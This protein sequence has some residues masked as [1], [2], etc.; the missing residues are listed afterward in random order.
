MIPDAFCFYVGIRVI[1][2][3]SVFIS[4]D[5][6]AKDKS[7]EMPGLVSYLYARPVS[8]HIIVVVFQGLVTGNHYSCG[9]ATQLATKGSTTIC[10]QTSDG[11]RLCGY[12]DIICLTGF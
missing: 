1:A 11:S 8:H 2:P 7:G 6:A 3:E 5:L 12:S 4:R 10:Y 9:I